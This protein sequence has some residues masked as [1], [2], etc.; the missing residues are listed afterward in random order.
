MWPGQC[1]LRPSTEAPVRARAVVLRAVILIAPQI[2][3]P[4]LTASED[5][6][7]W[8]LQSAPVEAFTLLMLTE[9]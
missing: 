6:K 5:W 3:S 9:A 2:H 1:W 7:L 8:P 4:H